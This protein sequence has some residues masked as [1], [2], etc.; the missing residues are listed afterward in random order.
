MTTQEGALW[1]Q[2]LEYQP[3]LLR[4]QENQFH[5]NMKHERLCSDP[6]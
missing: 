6:I 4:V 2:N 5:R 1:L 3:S